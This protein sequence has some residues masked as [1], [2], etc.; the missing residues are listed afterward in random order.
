MR[1]IESDCVI[2]FLNMQIYDISLTI[3]NNMPVFPGDPKVNIKKVLKIESGDPYNISLICLGSHNG[4]HV[5]PPYH[6]V[7]KGLKI[8]KLPLEVLVG[9]AVVFEMDGFCYRRS[10]SL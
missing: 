1:A 8:D 9:R 3:S 7:D 2:I 10:E 6:F 5:D 4:T